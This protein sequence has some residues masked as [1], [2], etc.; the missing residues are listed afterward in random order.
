MTRYL[1]A[2]YPVDLNNQALE[3]IIHV[4]WKENPDNVYRTFAYCLKYLKISTVNLL[5]TYCIDNNISNLQTLT[6]NR[7]RL[8]ERN[9]ELRM[10]G[11]K[12]IEKFRVYAGR[13][14]LVTLLYDRDTEVKQAARDSLDRLKW[15][16]KM[17]EKEPE[18]TTAVTTTVVNDT[19][20]KTADT[21]TT[22]VQSPTAT[23]PQ[24]QVTSQPQQSQPV[25]TMQRSQTGTETRVQQ[26][27]PNREIEAPKRRPS[28]N[29]KD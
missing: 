24:Q 1:N 21:E 19:E 28:R 16:D 8:Y 27:R 12:Y 14:V 20:T 10:N 15:S 7:L 3:A 29:K 4:S 25:P 26:S 5:L 13:D 11:I 6:L 17:P 2:S 23:Q 9:K 18:T 22:S